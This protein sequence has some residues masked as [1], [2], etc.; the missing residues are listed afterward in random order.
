M[1]GIQDTKPGGVLGGGLLGGGLLGGGLLGGG[2]LGGGLLGG[3][4]LGGLCLGRNVNGRTIASMIPAIPIIH[5]MTIP[6]ICPSVSDFAICARVII[7]DH[8][9]TCLIIHRHIPL[10]YSSLDMR[11]LSTLN[12]YKIHFFFELADKHNTGVWRALRC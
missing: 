7:Y 12:G 1:G 3:G 5:A 9:Y 6:A 4:L 11:N 10:P 8:F 2:L